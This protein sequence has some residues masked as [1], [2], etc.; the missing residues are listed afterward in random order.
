MRC[1]ETPLKT[2]S[3]EQ[4]FLKGREYIA[5]ALEGGVAPSKDNSKH[6]A[7]CPGACKAE[8]GEQTGVLRVWAGLEYHGEREAEL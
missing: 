8:L 2:V 5:R 4:Y 3:L 1:Q 6:K 7:R